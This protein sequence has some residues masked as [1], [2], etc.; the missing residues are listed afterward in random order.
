MSRTVVYAGTRNLY[1]N[2]CT[3]AKSLLLYGGSVDRVWFLIEDDEFPEPLPDIIRC[4]NVSDQKWFPHDGPNYES[5]WTY[6]TLMRLVLPELFPD[7]ERLLWLDVDTLINGDLGQLWETNL[8]GY[9]LAAVAEPGRS[10][11]PFV[12]YNAGVQLVNVPEFRNVQSKLVELINRQL[13]P[14]KDQDAINLLCQTRIRTI[15]PIWNSCQWTGQPRDARILHYAAERCYHQR[16]SWQQ[17]EA[18]D[19]R[20]IHASDE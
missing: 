12:Y 11:A 5:R 1:H 6:M 18:K 7:E 9:L 13:L 20:E 8:D 4:R 16:A 2:M 15:P 17:L 14:F 3:A 19:W 10:A